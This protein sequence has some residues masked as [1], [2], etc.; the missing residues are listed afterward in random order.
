MSEHCLPSLRA[1]PVFGFAAH[2]GMDALNF[3]LT[4]IIGFCAQLD[5][6]CREEIKKEYIG[7]V[8]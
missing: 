3:G 6:G 7:I 4:S 2:V 8:H 5:P 1:W